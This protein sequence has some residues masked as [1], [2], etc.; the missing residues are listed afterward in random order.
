LKHSVNEINETQNLLER[1]LSLKEQ[2]YANDY[3]LYSENLARL[4]AERDRVA[5]ENLEKEKKLA[6]AQLAINTALQ[7]SEYTIAAVKLFSSSSTLGPIVRRGARDLAQIGILAS[8]IAQAR[9]NAERNSKK[10]L[11]STKAARWPVPC[12]AT[13][14]SRSRW[15][16]GNLSSGAT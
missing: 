1:E 4:T 3:T 16:A 14:A 7:V 6:N 8:T 5:A 15:K 10:Y 12:M 2:G 9:A 13:A 11:P